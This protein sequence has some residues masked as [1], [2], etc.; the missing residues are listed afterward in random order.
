MPADALEGLKKLNLSDAQSDPMSFVKD[1]VSR[2]ASEKPEDALAYF[3]A[4][5]A[6]VRA[7]GSET[8][9]TARPK[10]Q[11]LSH[12]LIAALEEEFSAYK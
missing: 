2:L 1:L 4:F 9:A 8:P 11:G 10:T 12:E 3:E 6:D 7:T 5:S